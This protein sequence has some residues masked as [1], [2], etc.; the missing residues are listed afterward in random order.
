MAPGATWF[1]S[2]VTC[3][4]QLEQLVF[5]GSPGIQKKQAFFQSTNASIHP[6]THHLSTCTSIYP[7]TCLPVHLSVHLPIIHLFIHLPTSSPTYPPFYPPIHPY[8][9]PSTPTSVHLPIDLAIHQFIYVSTHLSIHPPNASPPICSPIYPFISPP[10][11]PSINLPT[12]S[13]THPYILCHLSTPPPHLHPP[14]H[15]LIEPSMPDRKVWESRENQQT[16]H[17]HIQD[18]R[19]LKASSWVSSCPWKHPETEEIDR[20]LLPALLKE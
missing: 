8:I 13:S 19:P 18:L 4:L 6:S 5:L 20:D 17:S 14:T 15:V 1:S 2:L 7:S 9:Y 16:P 12:H 3:Y 11:H 10:V